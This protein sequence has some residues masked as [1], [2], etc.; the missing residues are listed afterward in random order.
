[1]SNA[2]LNMIVRKGAIYIAS[3]FKMF[4]LIPS[5]R[6]DLWGLRISSS[7]CML[8]FVIVMSFAARLG[9]IFCLFAS[10]MFFALLIESL[11]FR[12]LS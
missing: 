2:M 8:Q 6:A 1:M 3:S 11:N 12:R 9:F 4:G 10:F 5:G 7:F